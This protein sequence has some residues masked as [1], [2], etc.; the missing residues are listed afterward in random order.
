MTI[1]RHQNVA[2]SLAYI[3]L[4][5]CLKTNT[6]IKFQISAEK[7]TY[8]PYNFG[9]KWHREN[10]QLADNLKRPVPEKPDI[11]YDDASREEQN[12]AA[13]QSF[14]SQLSA[15]PLCNRTFFPDRLPVHMNACKGKEGGKNQLQTPSQTKKPKQ[16]KISKVRSAFVTCYICGR[17][18]GSKSI[19]IHEP[20]CL[21]KWRNE[22]DKLPNKRQ[23]QQPVKPDVQYTDNGNVDVEATRN[24]LWK[25]HLDQLVPCTNCGRTFYPDRLAAHQRG[26]KDYTFKL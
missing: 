12:D 7:I 9:C 16:K 23:R 24:A 3:L 8:L 4:I 13:W 6:F 19:A 5:K 20:H 21:E 22:N 15:C 1:W 17:E 10:E 25:S 18:F 26:C 11:N 14:C 2:V